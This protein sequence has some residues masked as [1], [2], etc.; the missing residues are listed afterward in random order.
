MV[1]LSIAAAVVADKAIGA[2]KDK[3]FAPQ[4]ATSYPGHQ[5][6]NGITLAAI[7]YTREDEVKAAFGKANPYKFGVL[8]ILLVIQNDTGKA[9]RLNLQTE[10]V[11]LQNDRADPMRPSDVRLWDGARNKDYRMP[12]PTP[13]PLPHH[14]KG[15]LDVPEIDGLAFAAKLLPERSSVHGFFYFDSALRPGA[16]LY[17]NGISDAASGKQFLYFEVPFEDQKP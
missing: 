9:L 16:Y 2:D 14:T 3:R 7:P 15:P 10:L 13:I 6:V 1:L 8:P 5:T 4:A 17:I 11:D 12:M